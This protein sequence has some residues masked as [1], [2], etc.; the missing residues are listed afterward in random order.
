MSR[1][2]VTDKTDPVLQQTLEAAGHQVVV[3]T[4]VTYDS[5]LEQIGQFNAL[6][7]RSKII[8]DRVSCRCKQSFQRSRNAY[9][10]DFLYYIGGWFYVFCRWGK[11]CFIS[12]IIQ[13]RY[14]ETY[15]GLD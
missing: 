15:F 4:S 14:S 9:Q 10:I 11:N 5:L 6:V 2:L 7:V 13:H 12:E 1:I 3:D 8:I